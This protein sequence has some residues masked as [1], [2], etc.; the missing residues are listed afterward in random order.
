MEFRHRGS[1]RD[2]GRAK[3]RGRC[4]I[5]TGDGERSQLCRGPGLQWVRAIRTNDS[6]RGNRNR[7]A[8]TRARCDQLLLRKIRETALQY[9]EIWFCDGAGTVLLSRLCRFWR[10]CRR[11]GAVNDWVGMHRHRDADHPWRR[12]AGKTTFCRIGVIARG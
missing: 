2:G 6:L 9:R 4:R 7:K 3:D 10:G 1:G 5:V 8:G 11:G 12:N